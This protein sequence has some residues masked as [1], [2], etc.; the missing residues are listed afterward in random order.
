M[1][2]LVRNKLFEQIAVLLDMARQKV[3]TTVNHTMV[4]TYFEIGRM[5]VEDE[6]QGNERAKY[7]Q[8]QLKG[9]SEKLTEQ[10][11]KG[12]S[13]SNLKNMRQFYLTYSEQSQ[14]LEKEFAKLEPIRQTLSSELIKKDTEKQTFPL[15]WSH[16]QKL[17]RISDPYERRFYEIE[18][19][20]NHWSL[21]ELERQ[22]D[23]ALFTRLLRVKIKQLA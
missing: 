15:S 9:L 17:I 13:V 18:A 19:E 4:Q 16:Y 7:A 3:M 6:L 23:S 2:E 12:F 14:F 10:F 1:T 22:Y 5:I 11:G 8:S 21:R 20:K